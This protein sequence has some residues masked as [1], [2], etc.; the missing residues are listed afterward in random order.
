[1][2]KWDVKQDSAFQALEIALSTAPIL[3]KPD[4]ERSFILDTDTCQYAVGA[5][6]SQIGNDG[7]EHPIYY[8]SRV[9]S[10][11]EENYSVTEKD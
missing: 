5:V 9:L 10:P 4:F 11:A 3:A 8:H 2:K 7:V 6:L 1:M